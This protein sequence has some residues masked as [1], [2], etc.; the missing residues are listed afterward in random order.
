M[1]TLSKT[2]LAV[3]ILGFS[4]STN[5]ALV[6]GSVLNIGTGSYW[7][8]FLGVSPSNHYIADMVGFNGIV[9]GTTQT[10]SGSH[11]GSIDGTES[12]TIDAPFVFWSGTGMHSTV[13]PA[14]V[15]SA[16]G[17]SAQIDFTG[18]RWTWNGMYKNDGVPIGGLA[19]AGNPN[20]VALV[21]CGVDC[22]TGDTYTLSYSATIPVND[23]SGFGQVPYRMHL[24][25][26]IAAVPV[27]AAIWLLGSGLVGLIGFGRRRVKSH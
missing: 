12:P 23:P 25:G 19:W 5:A 6:N 8:F 13:S 11:P 26:T 24:Q 18:L 22:G 14:N 2:V 10:A 27:P 1:K 16:S 3:G 17:N 15:L 7:E 4:A 20:G 21:T 9:L